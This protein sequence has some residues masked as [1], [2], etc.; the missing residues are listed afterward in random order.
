MV[1]MDSRM[2]LEK[3]ARLFFLVTIRTLESSVDLVTEFYGP[4]SIGIV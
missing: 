3:T 1:E 4:F 2:I